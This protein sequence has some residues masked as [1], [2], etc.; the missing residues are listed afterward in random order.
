L[1]RASGRFTATPRSETAPSL[2][3]HR[4]PVAPPSNRGSRPSNRSR[5]AHGRPQTMSTRRG[6]PGLSAVATGLER[7]PEREESRPM[8]HQP[9]SG[10]Q[11]LDQRLHRR[12]APGAARGRTAQWRPRRGRRLG[13]SPPLTAWLIRPGPRGPAHREPRPSGAPTRAPSAPSRRSTDAPSA[14]GDAPEGLGRG[15]RAPRVGTAA[16]TQQ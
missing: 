6:K 10:S 8:P 2:F 9:G 16:R 15:A 12:P 5:N 1:C 4:S 11:P 13:G 7:L 3:R 14:V